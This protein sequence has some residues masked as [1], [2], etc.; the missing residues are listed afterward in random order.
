MDHLSSLLNDSTVLSFLKKFPQKEWKE[1]I[2][3]TL[4]L[5]IHSMNTISSLNLKNLSPE[6]HLKTVELD[7]GLEDDSTIVFS[8]DVLKFQETTP[9]SKECTKII[10]TDSKI[11]IKKKKALSQVT[12]TKASRITPKA[13]R[14]FFDLNSLQKVQKRIHSVKAKGKLDVSRAADN[15]NFHLENRRKFKF[16][17]KKFNN[18]KS[19]KDIKKKIV[20]LQ[21]SPQHVKAPV[22]NG[23]SLGVN[24]FRE[25]Y[26]NGM[27]CRHQ[28]NDFPLRLKK[29]VESEH[30]VYVTSSSEEI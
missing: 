7:G 3:E 1:V 19:F 26:R 29:N 23:V 20:D 11:P 27:S 14:P 12:K 6:R 25:I 18:A 30:F 5:G 16:E 9:S 8:E 22:V 2:K 17:F 21:M 4:K 24:D 15:E 13:K 10:R 28:N